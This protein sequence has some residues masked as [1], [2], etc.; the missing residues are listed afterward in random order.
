[1]NLGN[2]WPLLG[3]WLRA[4]KLDALR[5]A[6]QLQRI[7]SRWLARHLQF[8]A[9]HS[10]FYRAFAGQP[11]AAWPVIDKASWLAGFD[12]INTVGARLQEVEAIALRAEATRDFTPGWNGCTVGLSTGTSGRRGLFLA[13]AAER[14]RW[15]GTTLA[16]VLRQSPWRRERIALVLRS[17]STLY[18]SVSAGRLQFRYFDPLRAWQ[19]LGDELVQFAPTV[20][21]APAQLLA[22]LATQGVQLAPRRVIS[23]AEVLDDLDRARIEGHFGVMVEQIYQATEGFLGRS[24]EH[25]TLH[26]NEPFVL[27]EREWQDQARTRF[28][29]VVT[30]LWR[31]AQ[32]VVRYRLDDVLRI[33]PMPCP[34]GRP[35]TALAAIEG[36]CDDVLMLDGQ[37]ATVP[38]FADQLARRITCTLP[39]LD[40]YAVTETTPGHWNVALLPLPQPSRQQLLH[41]AITALALQLGA[42]APR[43][44]FSTLQ[45]AVPGMQ[46]QRR[47]RG[48]G[49]TACAS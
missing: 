10:P 40:D 21:V 24:C 1:M 11:L 12:T 33:A 9:T 25:G 47:I 35:S 7:Q 8:V 16:T 5:D 17:G 13:S 36:R 31:R 19:A 26:L 27:V 14:A 34:C 46:K 42:A 2:A 32:P 4:R 37:S 39:E 41:D 15:A 3:A 49:K 20:L 43:L 6:A 30:D 38:V 44:A 22:R 23:V 28:V 18:E 45:P 48:A 29:P